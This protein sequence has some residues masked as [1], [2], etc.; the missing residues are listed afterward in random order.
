[1]LQTL[2]HRHRDRWY[3]FAGAKVWAYDHTVPWATGHTSFLMFGRYG[4]LPVDFLL[5][6]PE[7]MK[8]QTP[9]CRN[10]G[11]DYRKPS[12]WCWI[13]TRTLPKTLS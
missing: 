9:G 2:K 4:R 6:S 8:S 1:M 12:K 10:T 11:I 7:D 3:K 13:D 5:G